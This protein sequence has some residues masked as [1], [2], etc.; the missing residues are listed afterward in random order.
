M[1]PRAASGDALGR[2]LDGCASFA[3]TMEAD[4]ATAA[5]NVKELNHPG[6]AFPLRFPQL[7]VRAKVKRAAQVVGRQ[8]RRARAA[9]GDQADGAGTA[10]QGA[11]AAPRG[12]RTG[13]GAATAARGEC[14]AHRH[15]L[16]GDHQQQQTEEDD[17]EAVENV[18]QRA[19]TAGVGRRA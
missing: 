17:Q 16:S 13:G 8:D 6:N 4:E 10:G 14:A 5:A 2:A 9:R 3:R 19:A 18:A 15:V 7:G 1:A 11:R 12:T